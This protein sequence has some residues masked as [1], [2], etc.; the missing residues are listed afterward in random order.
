MYPIWPARGKGSPDPVNCGQKY[1]VAVAT[2]VP[3]A[4]PPV[5]VTV[6]WEVYPLPGLVIVS[7]AV[8][9]AFRVPLSTPWPLLIPE[10]DSSKMLF[11]QTK[12]ETTAELVLLAS[13]NISPLVPMMVLF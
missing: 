7:A 5:M 10:E 8:S 4:P 6:G 1:A 13:M 3:V 12:L 9:M 2:L 11:S